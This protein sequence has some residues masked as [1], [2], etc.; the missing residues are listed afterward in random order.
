MREGTP[1][2]ESAQAP[3]CVDALTERYPG[4][5]RL[6]HVP[7]VGPPTRVHRLSSLGAARGLELWAKRDDHSSAIYGGNK[8]RKLE[9]ILGAAR[10]RGARTLLTFGGIGTH[11]GLATTV[12]GRAVGMRTVLVMVPQPMSAAVRRTLLLAQ[13]FGAELHWAHGVPGVTA[14]ALRVLARTTVRGETP[15]VIAPGGSSVTGTIGFVRAGLELAGQIRAGDLPEPEAIYVPIGTGGTAAGLALGLRMAGLRAEV[16]GVL[17]TDMLAPSARRL[18]R[19]AGRVMRRLRACDPNVPDL[20]LAA[21][22]VRIVSRFVGPGYGATTV[23]AARA[24]AAIGEAEDI[25]V[26]TTYTAKCLAALLAEGVPGRRV[27]FWNT[28]SAREPVPPGGAL[29]APSALPA[30]FGR[31]FASEVGA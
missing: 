8:P 6:P 9:Y 10:Q 23:E 31:F 12:F 29:P 3:A 26:E 2:V 4:L 14:T 17:V 19:L 25:A 11:H 30:A 24:M 20:T 27:L 5:G 28:F 7:L 21:G 18:R 22:D 16:V 1:I 13:A 15:F